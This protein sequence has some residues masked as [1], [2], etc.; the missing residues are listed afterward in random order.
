M[1]I[2]QNCADATDERNV[3]V[4]AAYVNG[5]V[6]RFSG[7]CSCWKVISLTSTYDENPTVSNSFSECSECLEEVLSEV[8]EYE[9]RDISYAVSL[10][11]PDV[12]PE[13]RGFKECCV[14]SIVFGDLSDTASYKNDFTTVFYKKQTPNDTVV[15]KIIGV[16]TGT[17]TLVDGTHGTLYAF[18]GSEQPDLSYFKVEWRKILST[19]GEDIYTIRKELTIAGVSANVDSSVT[20]DLR[21]FSQKTADN[22]V[23]IDWTL[24]GKLVKIDTDFKNTNYENS[25][26]MQGFFGDR[27]AKIEQDNV[28]FSSKK[29]LSYYQDQITMTN[30]YEYIFNAY[31]ISEC[32][33]RPLYEEGIF[34]NEFFISDYNLN[35]H[36][37]FY[38]LLPVILVDDNG[39]EYQV[40]GRGM[41]V[42]LTFA[43]RTKDNRKTN[44]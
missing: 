44:C 18:G 36:S 17:T 27:Q 1:Y 39:A 10:A 15:Y 25:I 42:N 26:R 4:A 32:I 19:L 40:R 37:Y 29:G 11:F 16:T 22:T 35:N 38:E 41:D 23:R 24:D 20:Y 3:L 28:T 30:N 43:D 5:T 33:V 9:E 31:N 6:L 34:G 2:V 8:C 14:S 21:Q 7:E 12:E 13:D